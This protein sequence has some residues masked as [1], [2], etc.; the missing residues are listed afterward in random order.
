MGGEGLSSNILGTKAEAADFSFNLRHLTK[1]TDA[2]DFVSPTIAGEYD[3]KVWTLKT[4]GIQINF[5]DTEIFKTA[6]HNRESRDSREFGCFRLSRLPGW[7]QKRSSGWSVWCF[8]DV[9]GV[10]IT[11]RPNDVIIAISGTPPLFTPFAIVSE[12]YALDHM[13]F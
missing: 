7:K 8:G 3:E 4:R 12:Q 1:S 9:S 5:I 6:Q 10:Q 2:D 13:K 11:L